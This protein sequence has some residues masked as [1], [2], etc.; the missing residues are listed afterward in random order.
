MKIFPFLFALVFSPLLM[1]QAPN[2][3]ID[4]SSTYYKIK[5]SQSGIY[6]IPQSTLA[7]AGLN[8]IDGSALRLYHKGQQVPLYVTNNGTLNTGDYAEF[9]GTRNDGSF[10]TQLY[11]YPSWQPSSRVSLFSDTSAYFLTVAPNSPDNLRYQT[12]ANDPSNAPPADTFFMHES[13]SIPNEQ[14][15]EG[16]PFSI[17]G[18]NKTFSD[19]DE[20]EGF[21]SN[22]I[23][24]GQ[25]RTFNLNTSNLAAN[26]PLAAT[27]RT[28]VVGRSNAPV[29]NDHHLQISIGNNMLVDEVYDGY[30]RK[31]YELTVPL[32]LLGSTT[33]GIQYASLD[34][35]DIADKHSV[36]SISITYPHTFDFGGK[37]TF[38]FEIDNAD[39]YLEISNFGASG[40]VVLYDL[41]H[42]LRFEAIASTSGSSTIY[43]FHLPQA[44]GG[45]ST[46]KLLLTGTAS[47]N[48]CEMGCVIPACIPSEC[49]NFMVPPS[50]IQ[51]IQFTNFALPQN[52]G[53]YLILSHPKL[54]TGNDYVQQYANYRQSPEGGSYTPVVV[55]IDELY[56]QFAYGILKH[57]LAIRNFV[58]FAHQNW[59]NTPKFLLLLGKSIS[60]NYT[61]AANEFNKCLVPTYGHIGSDIMLSVA[62]ANT[63]YINQL[64]TGRIPAQTAEQVGIYLDKVIQYEANYQAPCTRT[65]RQWM[66]HAL[67]IAGGSNLAESEDFMSK[68]NHYKQ[69]FEDTLMGGKVVYT[70]NKLSEQAVQEVDLGEFLNAGLGFLTFFGHSAGQYWSLDLGQPENYDNQGKYP[71]IITGSCFVGDIHGATSTAM[72]EDYV[73]ADQRGSIGFLATASLG[74]PTWLDRYCTNV[75]EE[76]CH[77]TYGKSI[78]EAIQRNISDINIQYINEKGAKVTCQEYTLAADPALIVGAWRK[79]ELIVQN[80]EQH[81]DVSVFPASL[82][83]DLPNFQLRIALSNLGMAN[84]DS[85]LVR[86]ERRLSDNSLLQTIEKRFRIPT[87]TDTLLIDIP[88]GDPAKALGNNTFTVSI[89][90]NNLIDEDCKDNNTATF[91]TFIFSDFLL[92]V[93]PCN[94]S[95]I[96]A[97]SV[98]LK[99]STGVPRTLVPRNFVFQI[100]TTELFNSPLFREQTIN[101][102]GGLLTWQVPLV[103]NN[104]TVYY[105][106]TALDEAPRK[107]K[108]A[109]F[110]YIANSPTGFSQSHIYQFGYNEAENLAIDST[111]RKW[112][113]TDLMQ[114]LNFRNNY[115]QYS[116]VQ[117]LL[118]NNVIGEGTCLDNACTGGI[119][120]V[121]FKATGAGLA[122]LLSQHLNGSGCN[123]RGTFGNTQCSTQ[124]TPL[125]EFN[126]ND[127]LQL[128]AMLAFVQNQI[129]DNDYVLIYS[130]QSHRLQ[131]MPAQY[132][133]DLATFFA[134]MN[135]PQI[136]ALPNNQPFM[137]L[138]QKNSAIFVPIFATQTSTDTDFDLSTTVPS[139]SD[140]GLLRSVPIGPA[141]AFSLLSANSVGDS[142]TDTS[143]LN[144][145]GINAAN[146]AVLLLG[147]IAMPLSG[148][149]NL[150]TIDAAQYR[151][152]QLEWI[153]RDS[154]NFT[155][156]NLLYWRVHFERLPE[157]ALDAHSSFVFHADTLFEGDSLLLQI[158]IANPEMAV[159]SDSVRIRHTLFNQNNVAIATYN[160]TYPPLA[161]GG[162]AAF[163]T[164]FNH[165][166]TGMEG[167][168]LLLLELN[169][170]PNA[171]PEKFAFNNV[172][173]LPF[174]VLKDRQNPL[175][176]VT[177]DGRHI[178]D[179]E[180]I[181]PKPEV[182]VRIRDE[183]L[184]LPLNDT[185]NFALSL[186]S[187]MP[188]GTLSDIETPIYFN[189]PNVTFV[190][191]NLQN[192]ASGS[193]V[194]NITWR[195]SF[196][197]KGIY[198]FTVQAR[199]R[200]GN[201]FARGKHH[202]QFSIDPNPAISRLFNYP[203]PFT[204]STRFSFVLSGSEVP[205]DLTIQIMT[206]SGRVVR[207]ISRS[208]LGKL[209][210]GQN[211]TEW[212]WDG[213]DSF[214]NKLA[215]GVYLYRVTSSLHGQAMER[216]NLGE[217]AESFFNGEWGKMYLMR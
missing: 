187:A 147:N 50:R 60:Y 59:E 6:R 64:A 209:T 118:N 58:N 101:S 74:F 36:A 214:G 2:A 168:N 20:C 38:L 17:S 131:T 108:N 91:S 211:L 41:D 90:P 46:R 92:P 203:N 217:H 141:S 149:V 127:A 70:Y 132:A 140:R 94:F 135:L 128:Q 5:L 142:P 115:N 159:T 79:T 156:L 63:N 107:W 137:A 117:C 68:L 82:S 104:N 102:I 212:A 173:H 19:F 153:N 24:E 22:T 191:A 37:K 69:I 171:Q 44:N 210:I 152:L 169:P 198:Q 150:S 78:G 80:D 119:G 106:R 184:F 14:H 146:E 163:G 113:Y 194:A 122:P 160:N 186:R 176:D 18:V 30:V 15:Y 48:F 197:Q 57:P 164:N 8:D 134:Q 4:Y 162:E 10:D 27:F 121:L 114:S 143:L 130:I 123:G 96:N 213:T 88:M 52:Q 54:R 55:N 73:L 81:A 21:I 32:N 145:Y 72:S 26:A 154:T 165:S 93:T 23:A 205:D 110:T 177:F 85:V 77:K 188:D 216:Y 129:Q 181:S 190:P 28:R 166:V 125:I 45:A 178:T 180:L 98:T 42:H 51:S 189:D 31:D 34:D 35:Q 202:I 75:Y 13:I 111:T 139:K 157:L 87:Y 126:T 103:L 43:Q 105:W 33:T 161:G 193:N 112:K 195:P 151:F 1:A 83:T 167:N 61:R 12:A 11:Q 53:N 138:A 133:A 39:K 201:F 179:G 207:E 215:N 175:L 170:T 16:F 56:D 124:A 67:H 120:F 40:Q 89:D 183:N 97:P 9:Y 49:V 174:T 109:S 199:D 208:E 116:R 7:A 182:L 29:L 100:D 200:S 47:S 3:W 204:S 66:K 86:I 136:A 65:D 192:T 196:T 71:L 206:I 144:V 99:A 25:S 95:I 158:N 62:S 185:T 76:F 148:T 172:L 155:P 84:N